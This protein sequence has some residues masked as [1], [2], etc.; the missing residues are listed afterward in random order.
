MSRSTRAADIRYLRFVDDTALPS[1][2]AGAELFILTSFYEGFG[3]TPLEAMRAGTPVVSST[4]G[5]LGEVLGEAAVL[6][7]TYDQER[8]ASAVRKA[9]ADT[10]Q[11]SRLRDAGRRR[12]ASFRWEDTARR[13][14]EVYRSL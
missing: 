12:A 2:Y 4:G 11:R 14:W 6:L 13:M 5:S 8:W 1:L 10:E 7:D 9:L 3:F